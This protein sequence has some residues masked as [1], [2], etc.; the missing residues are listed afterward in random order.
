MKIGAAVP[1]YGRER[2]IGAYL[3]M[4]L[5]FG[6]TPVVTLGTKAWV[7]FIPYEGQPD[8]TEL[9]LDKF[10]PE[11]KVIKG[12]FSHHRDSVNQAITN[13]LMG[14]DLILVND[15]DMFITRNDWDE[16]VKFV[17]G[18][19]TY[20]VYSINFE[21]MI[22]EYY[23]DWRY[24]RAALRGGDPPLVA[25]K[26]PVEFRHMTRATCDNEIVWDTEGPKYHHMR[27]CQKGRGDKRCNPP[28][29]TKDYSPAPQEIADRLIKWEKILETL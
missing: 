15:C 21:R 12:V 6:I 17:E 26:P 18:E 24:G 9:I 20:E 19:H 13:G 16:F 29:E 3:E 7:S 23:F 5:D 14:M 25:L 27:F 4:L 28:V 22:I 11:V 10:F 1:V 2:F 8:R